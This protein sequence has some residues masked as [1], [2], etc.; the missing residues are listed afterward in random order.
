MEQ[1]INN[2]ELL[3]SMGKNAYKQVYDRFTL[4]QNANAIMTLYKN[5]REEQY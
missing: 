4:Q 1:F 5:I 3:I 2:H